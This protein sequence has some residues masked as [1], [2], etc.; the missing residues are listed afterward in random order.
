MPKKVR[1]KVVVYL[2]PRHIDQ[3]VRGN[4]GKCPA[5]LAIN[6]ALPGAHKCWMGPLGVWVY[7]LPDDNLPTFIELPAAAA[8]FV[9]R[10]DSGQPVKPLSFTL[11]VPDWAVIA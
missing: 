2:E 6:D 3:G 9:R 4:G 8:G 11:K 7:R 5:A 1:S 10:F